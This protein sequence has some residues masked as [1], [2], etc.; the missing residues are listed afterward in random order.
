VLR[1]LNKEENKDTKGI[2][3][4][5]EKLRHNAGECGYP[6]ILI[7]L[8]VMD[9]YDFKP[10]LF[11]YEGPFGVG[12]LTIGIDPHQKG[13]SLLEDLQ[14]GQAKLI[15]A[16]RANESEPVKW[17]RMNLEGYLRDGQVPQLPEEFKS[18]FKDRAGVFVSLK[19]HGQLR[20]CIGTFLPVYKNI[21]EEISHNSLSAALND[22]RFSPVDSSE[23]PELAYSVDILAAPEPCTKADLDPKRYGVIVS[24]GGRRGLLLPDLE[25]VDTVEEQ[26]NIALQKGGISPKESY[27]IE[28]FEVKRFT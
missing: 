7:M 5:S 16:R 15:E 23:L 2:L 9:G 10:S 12:Y 11:S 17:A 22:P 21:A 24:S 4:I 26:L 25:G 18:L 14:A 1:P 8:G 28:R 20:G 6:Y 3:E 13:I 19:K 27:N